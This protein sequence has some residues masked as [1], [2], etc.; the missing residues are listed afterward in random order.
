MMV[1]VQVAEEDRRYK[2]MELLNLIETLHNLGFEI[3]QK[4]EEAKSVKFV[5]QKE[6]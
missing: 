2:L 4:Q 1:M 5:M 3:K 6:A